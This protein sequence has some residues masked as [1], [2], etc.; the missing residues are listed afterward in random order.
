MVIRSEEVAG[1][2]VRGVV[3]V[4]VGGVVEATVGEVD[5]VVVDMQISE[6]VEF[7][8]DTTVTGGSPG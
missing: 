2:A 1:T 6:V 3:G 8:D 7:P 5:V 4:S